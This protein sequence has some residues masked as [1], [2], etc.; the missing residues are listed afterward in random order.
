MKRSTP[1]V[2]AAAMCTL[3]L[4]LSAR[5]LWHSSIASGAGGPV[6]AAAADERLD[7]EYA[8]S[9]ATALAAAHSP[10]PAVAR[11]ATR[12]GRDY[13]PNVELVTHEGRKVHFFDDLVKDKVV[14]IN[15]IFTS[16]SSSCPLETARLV[17]VQRRL[18]ARVGRDVHLY[19][20]SIDPE[21]D[22]PDVLKAY[23]E[24]FQVGPGW[25]FLT[26]R[27]EDIQL[28]GKKLGVYV[29]G[30]GPSN[31]HSLEI[32]V[33]NQTT[34]QWMKRSPFETPEY[35]AAQIGQWLSNWEQPDPNRNDYRDAPAL[36]ATSEGEALF[37]SRCNA[38]H[39]I[40]GGERERGAFGPLPG[41]DLLG[42][43]ERRDPSW[44]RSWLL[45][46]E[47]VLRSGDPVAT[48]LY[49]RYQRV[50]MPNLGLNESQAGDVIEFLKSESERI[51]GTLSLSEPSAR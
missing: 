14:A 15:F 11:A 31:D 36:R 22:T 3:S 24:R 43:T 12:W 32:V 44:V 6:T 46:P 33:G 29:Q 27:P 40:G 18:G 30:T 7:Q 48:E 20:I 19:S 38:C 45:H 2:Y 9:E 41:P 21:H 10:K 51:Q 37:R 50:P 17:E 34:G 1:L 42:V 28:I 8:R 16:C 49:E 4:G 26:G 47:Q 39:S 23:A 25:L 35:L 5:M 13:F